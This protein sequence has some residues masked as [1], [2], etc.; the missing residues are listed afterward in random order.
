MAVAT[1]LLRT[2]T[3]AVYAHHCDRGPADTPF[4]E[5][6]TAYSLGYVRRGTFRCHSLGRSHDLVAGSIVV[7]RPGDEYV[8]SHE[9]HG[10]GDEC[11]AFSFAP[12]IV[13]QLAG[14]REIWRC[15]AMAP[16]AATMVL[17]ELAGA[18]AEGNTDI[19]LDEVGLIFAGRFAALALGM[20]RGTPKIG[21]RERRR[22]IESALWIDT[23]AHRPL[24]LERLARQAG[25]SAFHFLRLFAGVL[26][27]T[28]HQYPVRSRLRRAARLLADDSRSIS[29]I[30]LDV[31]F[32]D[33]SN[34]IRTF[35][36]AATLS[37][38][39]FRQAARG[40]RALASARLAH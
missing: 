5:V 8:C 29:D 31:G 25:F 38:R 34:F 3:V 28:P 17:G 21:A 40:E 23:D 14:S 37:P 13:E 32:G 27:V 30:A 10:C 7:G 36:R 12:E 26:G 35:H 11:L 19:G 2:D 20:R 24:S 6:H 16:V 1:E 39:A 33:L 15:V 9:H 18:T 4:A 22:I